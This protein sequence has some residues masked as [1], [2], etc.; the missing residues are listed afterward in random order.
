MT[1]VSGK[2]FLNTLV[3]GV[4]TECRTVNAVY[5]NHYDVG[6]HITGTAD[7]QPPLMRTARRTIGKSC[8]KQS[9]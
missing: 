3:L 4:E 1:P 8:R 9:L 5:P 2:N 7:V 6:W